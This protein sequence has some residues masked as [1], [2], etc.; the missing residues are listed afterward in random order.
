MT[1]CQELSLTI[2]HG[3]LGQSMYDICSPLQLVMAF[4]LG[5]RAVHL[6]RGSLADWYVVVWDGA[7]YKAIA[8]TCA[9]QAL[10]MFDR[11]LGDKAEA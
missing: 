1:K 7:D 11:C 3:N 9:E 5:T 4:E 2:L 8:C 6:Y 10:D